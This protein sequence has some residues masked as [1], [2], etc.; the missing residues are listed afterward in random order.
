MNTPEPLILKSYDIRLIAKDEIDLLATIYKQRVI[1][2][3]DDGLITFNRFPNGWFDKID[4]Y[5]YHFA[6]LENESVVASGR[7]TLLKSIMEHPYYPSFKR[8]VNN[9]L[10]N[11]PIGYISRDQV[12]PMYRGLGIQKEM[13]NKR[14]DLCRANG[15]Y[16]VY[17]DVPVYGYQLAYYLK[18]GYIALGEMDTTQV[19]WE[20]GPSILMMIR[21]QPINVDLL[22]GRY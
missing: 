14:Y 4:E 17:I 15:I 22:E 6:A 10:H 5:S 11:N 13:F 8:F 7:L 18:Q 19:A 9:E 20:L 1:C 3:N 16:D 12:L 2:R 21:L